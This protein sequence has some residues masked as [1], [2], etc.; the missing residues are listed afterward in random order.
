MRHMLLVARRLD[1]AILALRHG[2]AT[3]GHV[4]RTVEQLRVD[5]VPVAGSVVCR[6]RQYVP[7]W[8]RRRL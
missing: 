2:V 7:D 8:I 4:E 6:Q 3:R 5:Q 1:A